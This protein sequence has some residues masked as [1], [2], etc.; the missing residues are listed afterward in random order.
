MY[1]RIP[2]SRKTITEQQTYDFNPL[3]A[4]AQK[5]K[6]MT[7]GTSQTSAVQRQPSQVGYAESTQTHNKYNR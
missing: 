6:E 3:L 5:I 4:I 7:V 2:T 1:P